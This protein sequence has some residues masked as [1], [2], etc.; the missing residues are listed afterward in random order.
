MFEYSVIFTTYSGKFSV[1]I[2]SATHAS[3]AIKQAI[4]HVDSYNINYSS[5]EAISTKILF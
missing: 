4:E 2:K 3:D 5:V 1:L